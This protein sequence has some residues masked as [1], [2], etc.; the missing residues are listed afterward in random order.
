MLFRSALTLPLLVLIY[1]A[2]LHTHR[3]RAITSGFY[4][5]L[6]FFLGACFVSWKLHPPGLAAVTTLIY[7]AGFYG[8]V[9][10]GLNAYNTFA[11]QSLM[12]TD[13]EQESIGGYRGDNPLKVS[14]WCVCVCVC[15]CV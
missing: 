4:A 9:T 5:I 6:F 12:E 13:M 10:Q 7:I 11:S 14:D 15:L 2:L 1:N 3:Y 8:V